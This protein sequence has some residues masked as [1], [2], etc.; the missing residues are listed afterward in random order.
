MRIANLAFEPID[1][2]STYC[3]VRDALKEH[4]PAY[5]DEEPTSET[6]D[7]TLNQ[8][9]FNQFL[10]EKLSLYKV[11]D[12]VDSSKLVGVVVV[13]A[14]N[15]ITQFIGGYRPGDKTFYWPDATLGRRLRV[16][17]QAKGWSIK[18]T[19]VLL[20]ALAGDSGKQY[21]A[22]AQTIC[23]GKLIDIDEIPEHIDE[24]GLCLEKHR[25]IDISNVR[26]SKGDLWLDRSGI[27][28]GKVENIKMAP[29]KRLVL[30]A[31]PVTELSHIKG[32]QLDINMIPGLKLGPGISVEKIFS[33]QPDLV[34]PGDLQVSMELVVHKSVKVPE[35]LQSV[36]LRYE[37][38]K[39]LDTDEV[40]DKI[41][42]KEEAKKKTPPDL[43]IS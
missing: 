24:G 25:M 15:R 40:F 42:E 10:A 16:A 22:F 12:P 20:S 26:S 36:T 27:K 23:N 31:C 18:P 41:Q 38:V 13:N 28:G 9:A 6:E 4:R 7:F 2:L 30:S 21:D 3:E 17:T 43:G 1:D 19:K 37:D 39:W 11:I 33:D 34:L 35:R 29:K 32:G 5:P 14:R 8:D